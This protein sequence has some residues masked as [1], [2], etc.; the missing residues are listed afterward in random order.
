MSGV[1]VLYNMI[2]LFFTLFCLNEVE[3][4][5]FLATHVGDLFVFVR[6]TNCLHTQQCMNEI[7]SLW[8]GST[9]GH[10]G[11]NGSASS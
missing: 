6:Y 5:R 1:L 7:K 8:R 10:S 2:A 3:C 4:N 11:G 9:G